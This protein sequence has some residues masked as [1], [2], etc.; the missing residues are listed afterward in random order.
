M[1]KNIIHKIDCKKSLNREEN[2]YLFQLC[3]DITDNEQRKE[4]KELLY[5]GNIGLVMKELKN[6]NY[7]LYLQKELVSYGSLG[8]EEAIEKFDLSKNVAFSSFAL[9]VIHNCICDGV[10][11]LKLSVSVSSYAF[12]KVKKSSKHAE[13]LN[14]FEALPLEEI[15]DSYFSDFDLEEHI[16]RREEIESMYRAIAL[17]SKAEQELLFE[18]YLYNENGYTYEEIA[19]RHQTNATKIYRK[20]QK[21]LKEVRKHMEENNN[22]E[23]RF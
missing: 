17:L 2:R 7:P 22:E 19:N 6:N 11:D 3:K 15:K 1:L 18:K 13:L 16:I 23:K 8:L 20:I 5:L 4:I 9:P 21:I 10:K 12:Y 14:K